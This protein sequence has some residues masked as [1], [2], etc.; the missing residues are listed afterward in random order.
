VNPLARFFA[1]FERPWLAGLGAAGAVWFLASLVLAPFVLGVDPTLDRFVLVLHV[2]G[3]AAMVG[4]GLVY[5]LLFWRD[6][7]DRKFV[8]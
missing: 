2:L 8:R 4:A 5:T 3:L 7:F 6:F 1:R